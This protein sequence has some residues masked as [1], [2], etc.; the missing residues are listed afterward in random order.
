MVDD[1]D[2]S[3]GVGTVVEFNEDTVVVESNVIKEGKDDFK[4]KS[5]GELSGEWIEIGDK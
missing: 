1:D 2:E 5:I 4:V 3:F